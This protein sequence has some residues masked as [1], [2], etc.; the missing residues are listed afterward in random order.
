[1]H[2]IMKNKFSTTFLLRLLLVCALSFGQTC[3]WVSAQ[4]E[5]IHKVLLSQ[6]DNL[7]ALQSKEEAT[8]NNKVSKRALSKT[9]KT[10]LRTQVSRKQ[11]K[12]TLV[13]DVALLEENI[14]IDS[15]YENNNTEASSIATESNSS[16]LSIQPSSR[17]RIEYKGDSRY[18]IAPSGEVFID[19]RK[20]G[21]IYP[22]LFDVVRKG[23]S[24]DYI[25]TEDEDRGCNLEKMFLQTVFKKYGFDVRRY[26]NALSSQSCQ[27]LPSAEEQELCRLYHE[28]PACSG[29]TPLVFR[30]YPLTNEQSYLTY[31]K[32]SPFACEAEI[33]PLLEDTYVSKQSKEWSKIEA[34]LREKRRALY[35]SELK[36]KAPIS[37]IK[38][39]VQVSNPAAT[40][41]DFDFAVNEWVYTEA[42]KANFDISDAEIASVVEARYSPSSAMK[43]ILAFKGETGGKCAGKE[44][45][46]NS[47]VYAESMNI[48]VHHVFL[49]ADFVDRS[50]ACICK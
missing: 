2:I 42:K 17:G 46:Y 21:P 20:V 3:H 48:P 45:R 16:Q 27:G 43:N 1:M 47:K 39:S 10:S 11:A 40:Q 8:Q 18:Y 5:P 6:N 4:D 25:S 22:N 14:K 12:N 28:N 50:N 38:Q 7:S 34:D 19:K 9:K 30:V 37:Q 26:L 44:A 31:R 32:K 41:R 13:P 15:I 23:Y 29:A 33:S 49:F 36:S 35:T 24:L